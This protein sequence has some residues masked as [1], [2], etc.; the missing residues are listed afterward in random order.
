VIENQLI[1]DKIMLL[2]LLAQAVMFGVQAGRGQR[3][4]VSQGAWHIAQQILDENAE[5]MDHRGQVIGMREFAKQ[6]GVGL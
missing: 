4:Y 6:F 5:V 1:D 3:D 2:D